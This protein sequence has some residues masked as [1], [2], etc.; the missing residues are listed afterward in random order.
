MTTKI[1]FYGSLPLSII[2][3]QVLMINWSIETNQFS[4]F[5]ETLK[6]GVELIAKRSGLKNIQ[7]LIDNSNSNTADKIFEIMS[8]YKKPKELSGIG[9]F[10]N[11]LYDACITKEGN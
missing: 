3:N 8:E 5:N 1:I 10:V 11:A 2:V 9:V 7:Q 6:T 4:T